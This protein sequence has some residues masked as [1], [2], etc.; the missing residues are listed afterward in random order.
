MPGDDS[1]RSSRSSATGMCHLRLS[2][3]RQ[4]DDCES[5]KEEQLTA[6]LRAV[7]VVSRTFK[8]R[9]G[10]TRNR[11]TANRNP[12]LERGRPAVEDPTAR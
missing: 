5:N 8:K 10:N 11:L 2:T 1:W 7:G 6:T 9:A 12:A 3:D 4:S